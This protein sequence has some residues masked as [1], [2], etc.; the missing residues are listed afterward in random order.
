MENSIDW[1]FAVDLLISNAGYGWLNP[2]SSSDVLGRCEYVDWRDGRQKPAKD[3]LLVAWQQYTEENERRAREKQQAK[4]Q[5]SEKLAQSR[6][7]KLNRDIFTQ[8]DLNQIQNEID[9]LRNVL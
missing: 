2:N 6:E 8:A 1:R 5:L 4:K 3:D 9:L 7:M